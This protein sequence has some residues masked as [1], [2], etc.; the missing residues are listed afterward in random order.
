MTDYNEGDMRRVYL[1]REHLHRCGCSG[2]EEKVQKL[3]ARINEAGIISM[4]G[5][6]RGEWLPALKG[7]RSCPE[8][9]LERC[10]DL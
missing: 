7:Q 1:Q 3:R 9:L 2:T 10:Y 6:K 4:G 8:G 5:E